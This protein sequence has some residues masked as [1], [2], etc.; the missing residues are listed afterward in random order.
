[1]YLEEFV[2]YMECYFVINNILIYLFY[3][4]LFLVIMLVNII[5]VI[6]VYSF[7]IWKYCSVILMKNLDSNSVN[8]SII[9]LFR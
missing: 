3:I 6:V 4:Y 5:V 7:F 2:V 1:M 9:D 8:I